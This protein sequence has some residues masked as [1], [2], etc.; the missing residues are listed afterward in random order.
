MMARGNMIHNLRLPERG[1]FVAHL[2][3]RDGKEEHTEA[4]DRPH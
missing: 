4:I 2:S 3:Y 1:S